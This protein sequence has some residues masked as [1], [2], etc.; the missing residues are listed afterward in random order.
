MKN[1][2][3]QVASDTLPFKKISKTIQSEIKTDPK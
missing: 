1:K 3:L 2:H